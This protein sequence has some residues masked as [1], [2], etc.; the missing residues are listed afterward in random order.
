[1]EPCN[2]FGWALNAL[3]DGK[4]VARKGWNGKGMFIFLTH[5]IEIEYK[6]FHLTDDIDP[7]IDFAETMDNC[8]AMLT[9]QSTIQLGWLASQADM[10]AE[11]WEIVA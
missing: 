6:K 8:V 5:P 1:M 3:K 4:K 2:D 9:A 10:L 7:N 11:D